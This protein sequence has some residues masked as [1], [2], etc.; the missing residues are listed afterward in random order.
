MVEVPRALPNIIGSGFPSPVEIQDGQP[1]AIDALR[2]GRMGMMR[3][4]VTRVGR[5]RGASYEVSVV[6]N[7]VASEGAT[8]RFASFFDD[9]FRYRDFISDYGAKFANF[10]R[11]HM[12]ES[13]RG[14][15]YFSNVDHDGGGGGG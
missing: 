15:S 3:C 11:G 2:W 9:L 12:A 4:R 14:L 7:K 5:I 10:F 13:G 8:T 1:R 6:A